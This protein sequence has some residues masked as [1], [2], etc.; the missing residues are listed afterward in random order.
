MFGNA[1][2]AAVDTHTRLRVANAESYFRA[3]PDALIYVS[4]GMT[5]APKSIAAKVVKRQFGFQGF[6]AMNTV[7]AWAEAVTLEHRAVIAR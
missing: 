1:A 2:R 6:V 4:G 3:T 5:Q 7:A